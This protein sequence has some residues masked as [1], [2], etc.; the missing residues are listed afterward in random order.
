[1]LPQ[2]GPAMT[3]NVYDFKSIDPLIIFYYLPVLLIST[4]KVNKAENENVKII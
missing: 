4:D 2:L 1:M 3:N